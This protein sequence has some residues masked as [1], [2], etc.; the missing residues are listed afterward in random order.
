[1][2]VDAEVIAPVLGGDATPPDDPNANAF[3]DS[4]LPRNTDTRSP[5]SKSRS[6]S[7][8][9]WSLEIASANFSPRTCVGRGLAEM[10]CRAED[11]P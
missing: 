8:S 10:L 7:E 11:V 3:P 1:M 9:S 2:A 5:G 6:T 4:P